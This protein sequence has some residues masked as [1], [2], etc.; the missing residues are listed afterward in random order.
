[1]KFN[2]RKIY[3][4]FSETTKNAYILRY[5]A[6]GALFWECMEHGQDCPLCKI[7]ARLTVN[8]VLTPVSPN[9]ALAEYNDLCEVIAE[10]KDWFNV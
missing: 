6:Y 8:E 5:S 4:S 10:F 1:M 7:E 3:V 2:P 9:Y